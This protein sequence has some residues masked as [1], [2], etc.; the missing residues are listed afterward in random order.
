MNVNPKGGLA[1]FCEAFSASTRFASE[2]SERSIS[3]HPEL[4]KNLTT[5]QAAPCR[6]SLFSKLTAPHNTSSVL[7]T[8]KRKNAF[9]RLREILRKLRMTAF[10]APFL[11]VRPVPTSFAGLILNLRNTSPQ[12]R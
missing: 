9:V 1:R 11:L 6:R 5:H 10:E 2:E 12:T 3:C 8:P 4:A 7:K